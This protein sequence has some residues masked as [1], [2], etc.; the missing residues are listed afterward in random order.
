M[1]VTNHGPSGEEVGAQ[2][3]VPGCFP[4]VSRPDARADA[5]RRRAGFPY[6]FPRD[7]RQLGGRFSVEENARRL[8][9]WFYLERRLAQAIGSWTLSIPEFEVKI[10]SGRHLFY[11]ADAARTLRE[12]LSE[13]EVTLKQVD[14]FRDAELDLL[15]EEILSAADAPELLVGEIGRAHV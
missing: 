3:G 1:S 8:L 5:A 13:Q 11:H 4:A 9:R 7:G 15:I 10:E 12:R 6:R 14:D 2:N